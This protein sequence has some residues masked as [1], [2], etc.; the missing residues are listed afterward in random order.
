MAKISVVIPIYNGEKT[1]EKCLS[2]IFNQSFEETKIEVIAVNDG[3]TDNSQKILEKYKDRITVV[4]Q[5]N[6]GANIARNTGAGLATSD[7]IIFCDADIVMEKIMLQ[8][9]YDALKK[10]P[11][12]SYVYSSFIFGKKLFKLWEFDEEKLKQMPYIHT[13]SLIRKKHF[14][15]FDKNLKK[16]QDWDLWLTMLK[17][18]YTGKFIPKVLFTVQS[19]GTM[20]SWLPKFMYKFSFLPT[21]KKYNQAKKIIKQKHN[22]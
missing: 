2:S 4:N 10:N 18:G 20:S 16:F 5:P 6:K 3:S 12:A 13:T 1:L 15:G 7:F 22:L 11:Q 19:G 21:V 14:P 8:E 17:R 9:M